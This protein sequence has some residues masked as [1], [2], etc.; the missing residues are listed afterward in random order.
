VKYAIGLAILA[1]LAAAAWY[2]WPPPAIDAVAGADFQLRPRQTA[3]LAALGWEIR[4]TRIYDSRCPEGLQCPS[5]G[6]VEVDC[7]VRIQDR[8]AATVTLSTAKDPAPT[9]SVAGHTLKLLGVEPRSRLKVEG[10]RPVRDADAAEKHAR[11]R[12]D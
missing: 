1:A 11:M 8:E 4:A 10:G 3:R 2:A 5:A 9:A 12:V 6:W 7:Q